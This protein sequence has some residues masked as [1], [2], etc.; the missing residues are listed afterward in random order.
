MSLDTLFKYLKY[1]L[2][3]LVNLNQTNILFS[4][5]RGFGW[6]ETASDMLYEPLF[7]SC[8]YCFS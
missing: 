4:I 7:G 8:V 1:C 5:S 6:E 3:M 2:A